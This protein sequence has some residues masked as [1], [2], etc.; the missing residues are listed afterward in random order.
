MLFVY[1]HWKNDIEVLTLSI[2][3]SN[4]YGLT[5]QVCLI[6]PLIRN[7][8]SNYVEGFAKLWLSS[9]TPTFLDRLDSGSPDTVYKEKWRIWIEPACSK[10][11]V[12]KF[13]LTDNH[14]FA[15]P[16]CYVTLKV[17]KII[18]TL[19]IEAVSTGSTIVIF[20]AENLSLGFFHVQLI[21]EKLTLP[22]KLPVIKIAITLIEP[23]YADVWKL[24]FN[25][26]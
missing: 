2:T 10:A 22:W 24:I 5:N 21:K 13:R 18:T 1:K 14:G 3:V 15:K 25:S 19:L 26:V 12:D 23:R 17:N 7:S 11:S 4:I 20:D 16:S 9:W 8:I 6:L